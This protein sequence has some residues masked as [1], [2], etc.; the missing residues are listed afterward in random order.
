MS[1]TTSIRTRAVA[2]TT[3]QVY[4]LNLQRGAATDGVYCKNCALCL[5]SRTEPNTQGKVQSSGVRIFPSNPW[6]PVPES[7]F[8]PT[9]GAKYE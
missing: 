2:Q 9:D 8:T 6:A 3:A 7:I 4:M 5:P 1:Q